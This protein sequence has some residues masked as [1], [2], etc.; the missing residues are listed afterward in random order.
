MTDNSN[1][2]LTAFFPAYY[3]EGNIGK[4]VH[5]CVKVMEE[6]KL[7]D[8][9][10]IIIEDGSPDKTAEVAD[11]LALQYEKVRVIHH[12]K[13]LGYGATLKDGF[14]NAKMEYVFYSDGDN[15]FD[16]SELKKFVA[17]LP[18]T[19]IVVGYRRDKE[20]S[21]YRK[22]TSLCYNYFLRL[23]FNI[24][25]WDIDCAFKLFKRDLFDKIDIVSVDAFIDAEIMLKAKLAGYSV[26]EMGVKHLPRL[27]GISTGAR[28]SVIFRT[29]KEVLDYRKEYIREMSKKVT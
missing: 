14:L 20:Y 18:Y 16:L 27:D 4:V 21:L 9:E 17:L 5:Q 2:S 24:H 25:Y 3:D 8:Y 29:I 12:E 15:Q 7:R 11:E 10:I 19:D 22:F 26:T 28:P 1:I 13:N 23:L 6:M